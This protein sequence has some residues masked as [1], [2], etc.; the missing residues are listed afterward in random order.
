M[1][2]INGIFE[3]VGCVFVFLN[4]LRLHRDKKVRGVSPIAVIFFTLWGFWNLL[5]YPSLGQ[6]FSVV[7]AGGVAGMNAIWLGQMV[8]Y[9]RKERYEL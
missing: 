7:G 5:Y 8:Y 6:W 3:S 2:G 4:V 9:L 1:D